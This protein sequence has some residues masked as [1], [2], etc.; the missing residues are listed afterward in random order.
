[1]RFSAWLNAP[2]EKAKTRR[3]D[4]YLGRMPDIGPF[5]DVVGY[6][7]EIGP[8]GYGATGMV[9]L[10]WQDIAAWQSVT[11]IE[12]DAFEAEAIMQLSCAYASMSE[13]ASKDTCPAPWVDPETIDRDMLS[14]R[15][16]RIFTAMQNRRANRG[17]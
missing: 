5:D 17:R 2:L 16:E 13:K 8:I 6:L 14:N 4:S 1:V 15:I 9:P 10:S 11:G 12:L 3:I 7:F